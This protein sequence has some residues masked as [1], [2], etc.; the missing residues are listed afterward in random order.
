MDLFTSNFPPIYSAPQNKQTQAMKLVII[1]TIVALLSMSLSE[2]KA[3]ETT[4][5]NQSPV[6]PSDVLSTLKELVEVKMP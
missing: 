5:M 2:S 6:L 3:S 4:A 1:P